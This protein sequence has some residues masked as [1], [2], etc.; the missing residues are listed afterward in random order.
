MAQHVVASASMPGVFPTQ[1]FDK[2]VLMDGGAVFNINLV[3]AV[4]KCLEIVDSPSKIIL[5]L[6]ICT[7][8]H[9]DT[10]NEIGSTA[11][12]FL[13]FKEIKEF[14]HALDDIVEF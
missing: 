12:N 8:G 2:M 11:D 6:N 4:Q 3:S 13:R 14:D 10:A 5:D 1:Q 7:N 9:L